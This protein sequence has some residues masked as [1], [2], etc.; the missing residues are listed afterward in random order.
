MLSSAQKVVSRLGVIDQKCRQ[1]NDSR[2]EIV[3]DHF[4]GWMWMHGHV[5]QPGQTQNLARYKNDRM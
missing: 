1:P 4:F 3:V 2:H 5:Y